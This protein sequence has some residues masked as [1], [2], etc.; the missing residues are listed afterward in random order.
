[1]PT[2]PE[3]II[4][5][6]HSRTPASQAFT[7]RAKRVLPGGDTRTGVFYTP[8]PAYM[9]AGQG[10]KLTDL[11]GNQ[12]LD[13]LNNYTSLVHGHANPLLLEAARSQLPNGSV[14]AVPL[15]AQVDLAEFISGFL[16]S[17]VQLRFIN[18]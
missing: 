4:A 3:Q 16:S 8:Y 15:V 7:E 17:V 14:Y 2:I 10:T 18:I 13:F 1:M 6:Y 9:V 11:D 12:Y 5:T